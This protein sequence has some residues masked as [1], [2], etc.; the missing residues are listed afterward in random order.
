MELNPERTARRR[1]AGPRATAKQGRGRIGQSEARKLAAGP[2]SRRAEVLRL[3]TDS[4]VPFDNNQAGRD[5]RMVKLQQK[6][7]GCFRPP[8]VAGS[9]CVRSYMS[10][11]RKQ[12]EGVA[13]RARA[14]L[15]LTYRWRQNLDTRMAQD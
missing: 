14:R 4:S 11:A 13:D 2:G 12:G 7:G 1:Q 10:T 9:I 8:R 5:L 15:R 6:I 3:L